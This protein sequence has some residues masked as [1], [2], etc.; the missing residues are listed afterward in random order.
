MALEVEMVTPQTDPFTLLLY[1]RTGGGKT[2][3]AASAQQHEALADVLF[4]NVDRG[5]SSVSHI[6]GL[7]AVTIGSEE[8][9][10]TLTHMFVGERHEDVRSINTVVID[11]LSA[12]R[13]ETLI[14]ITQKAMEQGR[15]QDRFDVQQKDWGR[16]TRLLASFV[17]AIR[18]LGLNLIVTAG[19]RED[20]SE[21]YS[22]LV[23]DLNPG[24]RS[25][26][27]YAVSNI[28]YAADRDGSYRVLTLSRKGFQIKTRNARFK[29][30][31]VQFTRLH[32][33]EGKEDEAEGWFLANTGSKHPTLEVLFNLYLNSQEN[34]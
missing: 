32:A 7:R 1:G 3:I 25:T 16:M 12:L 29:E 26:V 10:Q 28:W 21:G 15:R 20:L 24:L 9:I 22:V 4:V 27:S 5:M 14:D 31:L 34:E 17:T 11:S 33:P 2:T 30:A 8:D 6:P 19:A 13:D 23:P 18:N